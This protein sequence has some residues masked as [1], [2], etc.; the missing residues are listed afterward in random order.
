MNQSFFKASMLN[1]VMAHGHAASQFVVKI[2]ASCRCYFSRFLASRETRFAQPISS[3]CPSLMGKSRSLPVAHVLEPSCKRKAY[4]LPG[5]CS[6]KTALL[7]ELCSEF[8]VS[9]RTLRK[10]QMIDVLFEI[11]NCAT[12]GTD[13]KSSPLKHEELLKL[14]VKARVR[15]YREKQMLPLDGVPSLAGLWDDLAFL[16]GGNTQGQTRDNM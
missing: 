2:F 10:D 5:F 3:S 11:D 7:A 8:C 4:L 16:N 12:F 9:T 13:C 15:Y 6:W 1:L 14:C